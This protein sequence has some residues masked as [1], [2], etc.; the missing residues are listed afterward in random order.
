MLVLTL[1]KNNYI[2]INEGEILVQRLG[3]SNDGLLL[4]V[5]FQNEDNTYSIDDTYISTEENPLEVTENLKVHYL[6]GSGKQ[7]KVGF[8]GSDSVTRCEDKFKFAIARPRNLDDDFF[9]FNT[10][11]Y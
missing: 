4:K 5:L 8:E 11:G 7:I 2:K 6:K 10:E 1:K 9:N 3:V